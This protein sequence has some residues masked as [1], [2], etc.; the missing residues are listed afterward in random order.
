MARVPSVSRT[1]AKRQNT[2]ES[3][4]CTLSTKTKPD[5]RGLDPAI[6]DVLQHEKSFVGFSGGNSSW[7]RGSSPRMTA[8]SNKGEAR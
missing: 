5:S 8:E 6:D 3:M 4:P 2:E 7:M 1:S